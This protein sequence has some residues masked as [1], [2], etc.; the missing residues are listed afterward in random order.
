MNGVFAV[1]DIVFEISRTGRNIG[2]NS[3]VAVSG[4]ESFAI[5]FDNGIEAWNPIDARGWARRMVT[6]KSMTISLAGKRVFGCAG[7][8]FVAESAY[9]GGAG[10]LTTLAV[11]FPNGDMLK[12]NCIINV[13]ACGGGGAS[14]IAV[15]EF[16][17][18]SDGQPLYMRGDGQIVG[19]SAATEVGGV[20]DVS[21]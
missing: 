12:M 6:A 16:D 2:G 5:S 19:M 4:M 21:N 10:L 9:R 20:I 8:D 18:L 3:L 7:N 17:C 11:T 14:D 1:N 15:L 13:N